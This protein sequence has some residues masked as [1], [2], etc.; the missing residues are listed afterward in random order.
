MSSKAAVTAHALLDALLA[1]SVAQE[2]VDRAPV[3]LA[4]EHVR[5][6]WPSPDGV[7]VVPIDAALAPL[8]YLTHWVATFT[9]LSLEEIIAWTR[10]H[11]ERQRLDGPTDLSGE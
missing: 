11:I 9:D 6:A 1:Q 2:L 10:Q 4:A 8:L 7:T 3:E 5:E